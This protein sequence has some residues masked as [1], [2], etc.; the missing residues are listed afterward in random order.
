MTRGDV[1]EIEQDGD[2]SFA[3]TVFVP[4]QKEST[5]AM[6]AHHRIASNPSPSP[7]EFYSA[8]TQVQLP[9]SRSPD[10]FLLD[11]DPSTLTHIHLSWAST[12]P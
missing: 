9:S 7:V 2:A 5:Y 10:T 6:Q 11:P 8:G 3:L 4:W 12:S 1:T